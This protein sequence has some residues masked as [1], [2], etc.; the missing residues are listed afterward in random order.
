L[1]GRGYGAPGDYAARIILLIDG[2]Q[3]NDSFYG[4][5]FFENDG[6]LDVSLIDR[7]EYVPGGSSAGYTSNA[8]LGV[9][10]IITKKGS[11][12]N[13]TDIAYGY[14]SH[15]T[16]TRRVTFGHVLDNGADVLFSLSDLNTAGR[17]FNY[18]SGGQQVSN[19][20]NEAENYRMFLKTSYKNL[21]LEG[22]LVSHTK[23][24]PSY[25]STNLISNLPLEHKDRNSFIRLKYDADISRNTKLSTSVWYG[26]YFYDFV[27]F[28]YDSSP[29]GSKAKWYG[30]DCKLI[31]NWF[32]NHTLSLGME[33]RHDYLLSD[34]A[35]Y[36][37]WVE[38]YMYAPKKNVWYVYL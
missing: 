13:G 21:S 32:D 4:Q 6:L 22:A 35:I 5:A 28:T 27:D 31:G 15:N 7:V 9:I 29:F 12:I 24:R 26:Y 17:D 14:G 16:K 38:N 18:D 25:P 2:Y 8:L 10:N 30:Y 11:D 34:Y 23:Q 20:K 3:A 33:H 37:D 19:T 36:D 1:G